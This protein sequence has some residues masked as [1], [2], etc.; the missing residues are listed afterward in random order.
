[1]SER[2]E[3]DEA[4]AALREVIKVLQRL[5]RRA[6]KKANDLCN[7]GRNAASAQVGQIEVALLRA[8]AE[9]K[10]AYR[11]ARGVDIPVDGGV[12]TPFGGGS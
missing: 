10:A 7:E 11:L 8:H 2:E 1:M 4:Q 6:D 9:A 3:M 12:I 5:A